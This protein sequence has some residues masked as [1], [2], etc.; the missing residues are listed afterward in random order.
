M[1]ERILLATGNLFPVTGIKEHLVS[2]CIFP[3]N[4]RI[5]PVTGRAKK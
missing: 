4:E 5:L 1:K 3:V 2:Q